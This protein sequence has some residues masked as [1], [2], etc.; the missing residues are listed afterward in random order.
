MFS[1]VLEDFNVEEKK[2]MLQ[3][4]TKSHC[5]ET[6]TKSNLCNDFVENFAIHGESYTDLVRRF[7]CEGWRSTID[8]SVL[9]K[10][11]KL[12]LDKNKLGWYWKDIVKAG[13]IEAM[14]SIFLKCFY[15]HV[16]G[17]ICKN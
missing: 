12:L 1:N 7:G 2:C 3:D 4:I 6:L 5:E 8:T 15:E 11:L 14:N 16:D 9:T 17:Y 10:N 13:G